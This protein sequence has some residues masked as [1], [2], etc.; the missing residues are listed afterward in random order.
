MRAL[1]LLVPLVAEAR[2]GFRTNYGAPH[3]SMFFG[4]LAFAGLCWLFRRK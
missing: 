4:L 3:M 1:I 2:G